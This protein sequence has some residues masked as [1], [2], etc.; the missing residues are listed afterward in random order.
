M[1]AKLIVVGV[2]DL[3]KIV[4]VQLP[5]ERSKVGVLEHPGQDRFCEFVHVLD[6]KTVASGTPRNDVLEV[7]I[8]EHSKELWLVQPLPFKN[9]T[10][11]KRTC[12]ASSRNRTWMTSNPPLGHV[13]TSPVGRHSTPKVLYEAGDETPV[14]LGEA[15]VERVPPFGWADFAMVVVRRDGRRIR[16]KSGADRERIWS[17]F[18]RESLSGGG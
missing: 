4:F 9:G 15:F 17:S 11:R 12:R 10:K 5:D 2:L 1:F 8:F 18:E 13:S 14:S 3:V 6:D 16:G 7:G